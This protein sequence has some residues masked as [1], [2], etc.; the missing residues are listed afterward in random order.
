MPQ[1]LTRTRINDAPNSGSETS[2]PIIPIKLRTIAIAA[3]GMIL[4]TCCVLGALLL[5]AGTGKDATQRAT[6]RIEAVR[7]ALTVG[8]GAGGAAI[9]AIAARR[10]WLQEREH[11]LQIRTVAITEH[12]A[13]ERRITELY[14]KAAELIGHENT[15]TRIAGLYALSR[16]GHQNPQHRSAVLGLFSNL[17]KCGAGDP[18]GTEG[19]SDQLIRGHLQ[20]RS[21]QFWPGMSLDLS[22]A[23]LYDFNLDG[24]HLGTATFVST[25]FV[26]PASFIRA[27]F[28]NCYMGDAFFDG[29]AN[30][31]ASTFHDDANFDRAHFSG[32]T[33]FAR[34]RFE[35]C[36]SFTK[37][38]F[39]DSALFAGCT[40]GGKDLSGVAVFISPTSQA[41]HIFNTANSAG[42]AAS[43]IASLTLA[44]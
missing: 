42:L 31:S 32:P 28:D 19:P 12:D 37:V 22:G 30:L 20:P 25:K 14:G 39:G 17:L 7:V 35:D 41:P 26:G 43:M 11:N 15:I 1:G 24:C 29:S 40:V 38:Y 8:F 9:V 27:Q 36:C 6:L 10:Q 23:T 44:Y 18:G 33:E 2:N 4:T 13:N 16:L 3:T 21:P 34:V 5:I